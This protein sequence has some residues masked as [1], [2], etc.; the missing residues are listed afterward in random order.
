MRKKIKAVAEKSKKDYIL[1]ILATVG[2]VIV[3]G[4]FIFAW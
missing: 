4:Y 2:I 1:R 3:V